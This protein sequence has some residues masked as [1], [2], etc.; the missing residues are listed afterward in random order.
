M[1]IRPRTWRRPPD[2]STDG[3][4]LAALV[5]V[6]IAGTV[7][8]GLDRRTPHRPLPR[9]SARARTAVR[10]RAPV[11]ARP[12]TRRRRRS[13]RRGGAGAAQSRG[14][15]GAGR[16]IGRARDRARV[17]TGR[18][19][20]RSRPLRL[21]GA[22]ARTLG[23]HHPHRRGL[24]GLH[25]RAAAAAALD[26][27]RRGRGADRGARPRRRPGTRRHPGFPRALQQPRPG[28]LP[29]EQRRA[30]RPP[31]THAALLARA[32]DQ[33]ARGVEPDFGPGRAR[34]QD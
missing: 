14:P 5:V 16:G 1:I 17:R 27:G 31:A 19:R 2:G 34:R 28:G 10:G 29:Q 23:T 30:S 4:V 13:P 3:L 7:R 9:P 22:A 11:R 12:A 26:G 20:G 32:V 8:G 33:A 18:D 25:P 24:S 21:S 15:A 6:R